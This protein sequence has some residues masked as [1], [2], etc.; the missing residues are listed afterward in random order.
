MYEFMHVMYVRMYVGL[1]ACMCVRLTDDFI[2]VKTE[3]K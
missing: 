2:N 3:T 1:H